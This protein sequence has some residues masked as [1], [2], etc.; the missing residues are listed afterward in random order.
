MRTEI[1]I[2]NHP[3]PAVQWQPEAEDRALR[4]KTRATILQSGRSE[5][6]PPS[7]T[8]EQR[9]GHGSCAVM[10]PVRSKPSWQTTRL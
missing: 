1:G 8:A 4:P 6:A 10:P 5:W 7:P 2:N 3:A 9:M